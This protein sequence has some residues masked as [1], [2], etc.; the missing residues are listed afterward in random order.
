M[1]FKYG[2]LGFR[3]NNSHFLPLKNELENNGVYTVNLGDNM[4]TIAA[5]MLYRGIGIEEDQIIT[6]DRDD[7]P[8]Y[9][10]EPAVLIMN[11]CFYEPCFPISNLIIP[12]FIG[13]NAPEGVIY[14]NKQYLKKY[15]PIG[16]RDVETRVLCEKHGISAYTTGCI[17]LTFANRVETPHVSKAFVVYGKGAGEIPETLLAFVPPNILNNVEFIMQ[18]LP[19]HVFPPGDEESNLADLFALNLLSRYKNEATL[20]ITPLLHAACPCIAMGIPV[21]IARKDF[22]SRFSSVSRLVPVYTPERFSDIDWSPA[23][24]NIENIKFHMTELVKYLIEEIPKKYFNSNALS[25]IFD[26]N[27]FRRQLDPNRSRF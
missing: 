15:E 13:F 6:I 16:C 3:Y 17:T 11:G 5:R 20:V 12:I 9:S 10:G 7:L 14:N 25:N 19:M 26:Q 27:N 1:I 21:I 22:D 24:V 23:P 18:R 8:N 4:Q 2:V